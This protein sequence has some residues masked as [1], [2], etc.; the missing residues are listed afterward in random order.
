MDL[1]INLTKFRREEI[2]KFNLEWDEDD[3]RTGRWA[4][5]KATMDIEVEK[6]AE[7]I[8]KLPKK[9]KVTVNCRM[10]KWR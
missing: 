7:A 9:A 2:R 6:A 8:K 3:R 1:N 5:K 10:L 4:A